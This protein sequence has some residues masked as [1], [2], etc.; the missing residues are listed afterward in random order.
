METTVILPREG[1]QVEFKTLYRKDIFDTYIGN[2]LNVD[3]ENKCVRVSFKHKG[4][5]NVDW[6]AFSDIQRIVSVSSQP[7]FFFDTCMSTF[8]DHANFILHTWNGNDILVLFVLIFTLVHDHL[9]NVKTNHKIKI[10]HDNVSFTLY[11]IRIR[12]IALFLILFYIGEK[13]W[14]SISSSG[15][16][17]FNLISYANIDQGIR[18]L[19]SRYSSSSLLSSI[20]IKRFPTFSTRRPD[21]ILTDAIDMINKDFILKDG[22]YPKIYITYYNIYTKIPFFLSSDVVISHES[23]MKYSKIICPDIPSYLSWCKDHSIKVDYPN[24]RVGWKELGFMKSPTQ[25][26]I[27]FHPKSR[28]Y[29]YYRLKNGY[30]FSEICYINVSSLTTTNYISDKHVKHLI[31]KGVDIQYVDGGRNVRISYLVPHTNITKDTIVRVFSH[32]WEY[33]G[34]TIQSPVNL[35]DFKEI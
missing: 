28:S 4:A 16:N 8:L 9:E 2:V 32:Q 26:I 20:K 23:M 22:I 10:I 3:I 7:S 25:P 14:L 21:L 12:V 13:G 11:R 31:S 33:H 5:K 34:L 29:I 15:C 19:V 27:P 30:I 6:I 1:D 17:H 24:L 35:G 18:F